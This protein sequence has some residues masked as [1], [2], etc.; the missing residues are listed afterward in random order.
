[1]Y[2]DDEEELQEALEP[3]RQYFSG[4]EVTVNTVLAAYLRSVGL[5]A[6]GEAWETAKRA[7]RDG[8]SFVQA[9]R[10]AS[11]SPARSP[12]RVQTT[13]AFA[14]RRSLSWFP[15]QFGPGDIDGIGAKRLLGTPNI[16]L[17][18]ILV[19]ETAQ[20]SWDARGVS[21]SIDFA[22]NLRRLR[23]P[24][25]ETL[26]NRIFTEDP[27]KT[28]LPELLHRDEIWALEV[29]DR[30]TVGLGGPIRN[31]LALEPGIDRNFIDLVFNIGAPRD[32]HLGAG[33]A[34]RAQAR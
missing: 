13:S 11:R 14:G 21:S 20:N 1:M 34:P 31:D 7:V 10:V 18:S 32:V 4:R 9:V 30:R 19:R 16:D 6:F 2:E 26:R 25:I 3:V 28:G 27:P 29:S 12:A 17:A 33:T 5:P 24:L 15:K 8:Y 22:L 23:K